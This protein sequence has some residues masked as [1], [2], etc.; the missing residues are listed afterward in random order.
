[1]ASSRVNC[2]I[3][4]S[5]TSCRLIGGPAILCSARR[6]RYRTR[7]GRILWPNWSRRP[8]RL[9]A[10]AS[11]PA[12]G[13][14]Q[15]IPRGGDPPPAVRCC[16]SRLRPSHT[17]RIATGHASELLCLPDVDGQSR[18]AA[19]VRLAG[20]PDQVRDPPTAGL[21]FP[22]FSTSASIRAGTRRCSGSWWYRR[23]RYSL[24]RES[25]SWPEPVAPRI[26]G[27][28]RAAGDGDVPEKSRLRGGVSGSATRYLEGRDGH[29]WS[30]SRYHPSK[31]G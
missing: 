24:P 3:H 19:T 13:T 18:V 2:Q 5:G 30:Q 26:K 28:A 20:V 7:G 1:M 17:G 31:S 4:V 14:A 16:P 8:M 15:H 22:A 11:A 27:R 12:L 25:L 6:L 10:W 9:D 23:I 21:R 29:V